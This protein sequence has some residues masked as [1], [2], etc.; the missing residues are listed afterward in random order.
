MPN[1]VSLSVIALC[2]FFLTDCDADTKR[3]RGFSCGNCPSPKFQGKLFYLPFCS[4]DEEGNK[5]THHS[6]CDAIC[7]KSFKKGNSRVYSSYVNNSSHMTNRSII[8]L[9]KLRVCGSFDL[10]LLQTK[11]VTPP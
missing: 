2:M 3:V 11:Q 6:I 4:E 8:T 7:K 9:L 5:E 10:E 1:Y